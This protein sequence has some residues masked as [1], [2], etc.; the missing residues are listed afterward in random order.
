M[1][2]VVQRLLKLRF[3]VQLKISI[4]DQSLIQTE[5]QGIVHHYGWSFLR[6][7][8]LEEEQ[9]SINVLV[10]AIYRS[11]FIDY[12]EV[13]MKRLLENFPDISFIGSERFLIVSFKDKYFIIEYRMEENDVLVKHPSFVTP[14]T[15]DHNLEYT[16][17]NF[18][19]SND[20]DIRKYFLIEEYISFY[21]DNG[22]LSLAIN[23][24]NL[25]TE[26]NV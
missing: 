5:Y 9:I 10:N 17:L 18:L 2:G 22:I 24:V 7:V 3:P 21:Q 19:I 6:Y 12:L 26:L 8:P 20:Y 15:L 1:E 13:K 4:D 11:S 16:I 25:Y 14:K 23:I